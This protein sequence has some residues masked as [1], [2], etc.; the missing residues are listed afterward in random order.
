MSI[1]SSSCCFYLLLSTAYPSFPHFLSWYYCLSCFLLLDFFVPVAYPLRV[2]LLTTACL[3]VSHS[4]SLSYSRFELI[5]MLVFLF[6]SACPSACS[7]LFSCS[8]LSFFFVSTAC[9]SV[10]MVYPLLAVF[11]FLQ[12]C[13]P[14]VMNCLSICSTLLVLLLP[15]ACPTLPHYLAFCNHCLSCVCC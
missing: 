3:S 5:L 8:P 9:S 12:C 7:P 13:S 1:H 14:F 2:L 11:H 10:P 6:S 15:N 4:L